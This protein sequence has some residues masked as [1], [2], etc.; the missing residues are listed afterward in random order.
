[1]KAYDVIIIG[2]GPAGYSAAIRCA[3]LG[4]RTA[5]I[6]RWLDDHGKP[7]LGGS[8]VHAGCIPSKVLL[9]A[10]GRFAKL[11]GATG[12]PGHPGHPGLVLQGVELDLA[13][14]QQHKQ[15][16][17]DQISADIQQQFE[18]LT[19]DWIAGDA[20]LLGDKQVQVQPVGKGSSHTLQ[21]SHIII[22]PGS[23]PIPV[24]AAP[25]DQQ[26]IVDST[27]AMQFEQ[28]PKRLAIIGAG[29][30]GLEM[31]SIWSRLGAKVILLE[32]QE[33]FLPSLDREL[34][35]LALQEFT[36]Q[37]LEIR[38]GARV[39]ATH[40]GDNGVRIKY[41]DQQG[42]HELHAERLI[43]AAGRRPPGCELCAA[44]TGLQTD[45]AGFIRV[46]AH[47]QTAI[48]GVYAIGDVVRGPMLA[49]KGIE[50]ANA[51][52]ETIAGHPRQVNYQHIPWVIYTDPEL[53]WIGAT[54]QQLQ[55][56][57]T[58]YRV[59]RA[60]L[61]HNPRAL[62]S[63]KP[64]GLIKLLSDAHNDQL[65]GLHLMGASASE[66]INE[67]VLALEFTASAEDLA[68]TCHSHPSLGESLR[69]AA[70]RMREPGK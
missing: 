4:L 47:C 48:N 13:A 12:Y 31:A 69:T 33:D 53:A 35:E 9:E 54:E 49:H 21:A 2:A 28:V 62:L 25:V 55:A 30:I 24:A 51:V 23:I 45:E 42:E 29:V 1:M 46:D 61:Q 44:E 41:R 65:L 7:A 68:R 63:G 39:V 59:G 66:L 16:V 67:A 36:K 50:E 64:A 32:A 58:D 19:I 8:C 10:S 27:G 52:A 6:D 18:G 11:S 40:V 70:S 60:L 20:G 14:M 15:A 43:V 57:G 56:Q 37:G 26:R 34:S 17:V 5:C 3:E 38:F 22:A